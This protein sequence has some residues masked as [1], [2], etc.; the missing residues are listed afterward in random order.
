MTNSNLYKL[1]VTGLLICAVLILGAPA[2]SAQA[3]AARGLVGAAGF[4]PATLCSQSRCATRLRHA[5]HSAH[6][7]GPAS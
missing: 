5:P 2:I 6:A 7:S 3:P 1:M 4:E